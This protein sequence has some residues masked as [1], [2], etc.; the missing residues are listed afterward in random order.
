MFTGLITHLGTITESR[1]LDSGLRLSIRCEVDDPLQRGESIAVNGVC[2]TALP[3]PDGFSADVSDET[4]RLTTLGTLSPGVVVNLERALALGSRLG[5]HL[6]QGHVDA[7][8]V[9]ATIT[10]DAGF[11]TFRWRID[12][13]HRMLIVNKGSIAVDGVSLTVVDPAEDSFAAA[14]IP[15]T[16]RQ[17]NLGQSREG[18]VVNLEFDMMGKYALQILAPWRVAR[19]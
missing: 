16:L 6:V 17:T 5:G 3:S 12:P 10:H 2:L 18:D 9:V 4:L 1:R 13:A 15:E 7:R 14:I 19:R 8:G 11:A